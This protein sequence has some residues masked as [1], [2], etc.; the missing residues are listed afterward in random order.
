[1]GKRGP[2]KK[3]SALERLEGN[4]SK[5]LIQESGID[6]IGEPFTSDHLMMDAKSCVEV[7]MASMPPGTGKWIVSCWLPMAW[8]GR[9]TSEP[10]RRSAG[11]I[12]SGSRSTIMEQRIRHHG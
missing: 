1:M 3:L 11:R 6:G 2:K 5:R 4:P 7:I 10:P 9:H 12:L 8:H